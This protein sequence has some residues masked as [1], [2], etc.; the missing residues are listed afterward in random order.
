MKFKTVRTLSDVVREFDPIRKTT[1]HI[2]GNAPSL[3]DF[4]A[5]MELKTGEIGLELD[6]ANSQVCAYNGALDGVDVKNIEIHN[7]PRGGFYP[8]V[9]DAGTTIRE[10]RSVE[11]IIGKDCITKISYK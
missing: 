8:S 5:L 6:R 9:F 3:D 2:L 11:Y 7:H 1:K 10:G 4:I